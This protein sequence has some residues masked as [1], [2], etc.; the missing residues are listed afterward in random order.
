MAG[1]LLILKVQKV[2]LKHKYPSESILLFG[3]TWIFNTNRP[4]M[5]LSRSKDGMHWISSS[6]VRQGK[7]LS[8]N[9]IVLITGI[10]FFIYNMAY[11]DNYK[12]FI[13]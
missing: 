7:I 3:K 1:E 12:W 8:K 5:L 13:F 9:D 2:S 10:Y 11:F 4:P 6:G